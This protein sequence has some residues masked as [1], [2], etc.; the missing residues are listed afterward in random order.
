[1]AE[2]VL[3]PARVHSLVCQRIAGRVPEHVDM[4]LERQ[5]CRL[6]SALDHPGNAHAAEWLAALVHEHVGAERLLPQALEALDLVAVE[7]V[8]RAAA[9]FEP[10]DDDR[11]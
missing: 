10:P 1:M 2:E 6:A 7:I 5:A 9:A 4:R 8:C 3:Q 11:R